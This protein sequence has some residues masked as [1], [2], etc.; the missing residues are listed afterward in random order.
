[1]KSWYCFFTLP[2]RAAGIPPI[3]I[4]HRL[5]H[6]AEGAVGEGGCGLVVVRAGHGGIVS[7]IVVVCPSPR[8]GEVLGVALFHGLRG[9][10]A[11]P[12]ATGRRPFG[13]GREEVAPFY[14]LRGW[15][16][17][18]VASGRRSYGAR[19]RAGNLWRWGWKNPGVWK[20]PAR[21]AGPPR[22]LPLWAAGVAA[23]D[24]GHG[25]DHFAEGAVGEGAFDE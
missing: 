17:L 22:R 12:V 1:M 9:C 16:A 5:Y 15:A 7:E 10:A 8:W 13:A 23:V 11:L 3:D 14:G 2:L 25:L 4:R 6:F 21:R 18:P 24:V 20:N 19:T